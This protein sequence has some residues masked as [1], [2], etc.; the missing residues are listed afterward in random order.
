MGLRESFMAYRLKSIEGKHFSFEDLEKGF[1][2]EVHPFNESFDGGSQ[3]AMGPTGHLLGALSACMSATVIAVCNKKGKIERYEV[4]VS[5]LRDETPAH[6]VTEVFMTFK[7]WGENIEAEAIEKGIE[8]GL[9]KYC[10]VSKSIRSDI[11]IHK[12]YEINPK[13]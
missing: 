10:T 2:T 12:K 3:K 6:A 13:N 5:D 8:L 11:K 1:K 4:E 7:I 9:E